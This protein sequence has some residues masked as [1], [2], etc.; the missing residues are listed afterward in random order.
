LRRF[1][2]SRRPL[3]RS[4]PLHRLLHRLLPLC[5]RRPLRWRLHRLL[6]P[7]LR[8]LHLRP[9][10]LR[11]RRLLRLRRLLQQHQRRCLD[12]MGLSMDVVLMSSTVL[13]LIFHG[14]VLFRL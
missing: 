11:P 10:W 2:S 1:L 12:D 13:S 5:S 6:R 3:C 7:R 4:R 9:H 8:W 14:L